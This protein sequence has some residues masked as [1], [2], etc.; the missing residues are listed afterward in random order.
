MKARSDKYYCILLVLIFFSSVAYAQSKD[1]RIFNDSIIKIS[2]ISTNSIHSDFGPSVIKDTLFFTTFND[3]LIRQTDKKLR[4]REFYDLYKAKIDKE[5]NTTSSREPLKEFITQFNDG[6][7]SWCEKTGELFVTQN[8]LDESA[9]PKLHNEI[10]RLRIMIAKKINGHWQQVEDFPYNNPAYSVG[11]P[12]IT[13]SGDTLIFSSDKPGGFGQTDLYYS[14]RKN[15]K[16]EIPVNLGSHINTSG[17]E[18]FAFLTDQHLNGRFLI[19]AST[20]RF[21]NGGLDLYYTR[22]P[23]ENSKIGHFESPIN[24]PSDD[25]AMTIPHDADYGYLTSNRPGTGSDDIYKFT[26]KRIIKPRENSRELYVFDKNSLR[27][28]PGVRII[29]CD[30]QMYLTDDKGKAA[31]LPPNGSDCEVIAGTFGYPEKSKVLRPIT[32]N[33]KGITRDTIWMEIIRDQKIVLKNIYYDYDKW[34]ILPESAKELDKVVSF[35]KEN[36]ENFVLLSSHT[37]DRGTELYNLKLSQLRAQSAVDYI[38]SKGIDQS[39]ITGT[40]FGKTQ[41]INKCPDNQPCTPE[42]HR[43]NRRTEIFIPGHLKG[44]H[45]KQDKGDYSNGK[46]DHSI[47]YSSFK[48]HGFDLE[49]ET[50]LGNKGTETVVKRTDSAIKGTDSGIKEANPKKYYLIL[51]S[52]PEKSDALKFTNQLKS[53]GLK[54]IIL[55][56]SNPVRVGIGYDLFSQAKKALEIFKSKYKGCWIYQSK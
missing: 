31:S 45:V 53:E 32:P 24:T 16:W 14:V 25:F 7:V 55:N 23:S 51:A 6:P 41:L 19:F 21:G 43:Q 42:Q 26:F 12:A 27:P 10:N 8:Y 13:E 33:I 56:E 44:E 54:A 47:G 4:N 39:M 22:F 2:E 28:I 35:M 9:K 5:G 11:H 52:F 38:V 50:D 30:K 48:E 36:P 46:P 20:G 37:D 40:G 49:K 3:S 18:E 15:G 1:N 29:S 17:K 34:E